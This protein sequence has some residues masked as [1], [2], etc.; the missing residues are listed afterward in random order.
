MRKKEISYNGTVCVVN[1]GFYPYKGTLN[2]K[3][4]ELAKKETG[5]GVAVATINLSEV[6]IPDSPLKDI[7][8]KDKG[9]V[10]IKDYSEN[11]GVLETLLKEGVVGEPIGTVPVGYTNAYVCKLL[12]NTK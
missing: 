2:L 11:E 7:I 12:I 3:Y 4:I 8:L 5:E 1:I 6:D 9:Y 10:F